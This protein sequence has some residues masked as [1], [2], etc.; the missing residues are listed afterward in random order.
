MA[1]GNASSASSFGLLLLRLGAGGMLLFGH[2]WAKLMHYGTRAEH[3]FDPLGI[4]PARS[5]A[6]V[7]F[8]E[9]FC[10]AFV[11]LGFATRLACVPIII[12]MMVAAFVVNGPSPWGEKELAVLYLVPFL[13]LLFTGAGQYALDPKFGPKLSFKGGK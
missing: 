7:I 5:L 8:A 2:G 1:G 6:L 4:G 12:N 11:M 3:F 9:V 10:S 13:S